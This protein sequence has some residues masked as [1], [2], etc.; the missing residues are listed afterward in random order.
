MDRLT[1]K[2]QNYNKILN[3]QIGLFR[4]EIHDFSEKVFQEALLNA[5]SH[6]NYEQSGSVYV[7]HYPDKIVI[8]NPGG[9][10][11]GIT[12]KNIITHPS[13]PRNKLIAE[14]LQRLKYVQRTGQGV[15][16]IFKNMISM[17]KHFPVYQQFSDSIQLSIYSE[18]EDIEFVKFI[19]KEQESKQITLSLSELMVLRYV[20]DNKD[21]KLSVAKEI[22]QMNELDTRACFFKLVKLGLIQL[23]GKKY[24]LTERVYDEIKLDVDY[25]RDKTI[26]YIKAKYLILEYLKKEESIS[27]A[28]VEELCASTKKRSLAIL[29]DMIDENLIKFVPKGKYSIYALVNKK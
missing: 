3:V 11:D 15:D 10:I 5:L 26:T 24:T 19:I 21:I 9:F 13:C 29:Q 14:T 12:E 16:I 17:G 18:T 23:V 2:I 4:L 1:E 8:S 27:R 6:R 25:T 7:K 28:K 22:T 20:V